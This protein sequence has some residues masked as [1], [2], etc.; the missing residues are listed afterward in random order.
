MDSLRNPAQ[1]ALLPFRP[2]PLQAVAASFE[3]GSGT[4]YTVITRR[5]T[6]HGAACCRLCKVCT[7]CLGPDH[8]AMC[9][10]AVEG[11]IP[12]GSVAFFSVDGPG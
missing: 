6:Q 4:S 8:Q 5:W 11:R 9:V 12:E 2:E 10:V 7:A 1:P 3:D